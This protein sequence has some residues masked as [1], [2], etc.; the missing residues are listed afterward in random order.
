[1]YTYGIVFVEAFETALPVSI[2]G[3]ELVMRADDFEFMMGALSRDVNDG[4]PY[5]EERSQH[6]WTFDVTPSEFRDFLVSNSFLSS[7]LHNMDTSLPDWLQFLP[8]GDEILGVNDLQTDLRKG[9]DIQKTECRG[10]PLYSDRLYTVLKF[11][12]SFALS[13]FG[14]EIALPTAVSNKMYCII[15]D[16]CQDYGGSVFLILPEK[17]RDILDNVDMFKQII[18]DSG[19][20]IRP[21]GVGLSLQK[22]INV[23]AKTT[24]LQQW[25]GDEIIQYPVFQEANIWIGGDVKMAT[26]IFR[27]S[28]TTNAFLSIL[29]PTNF[30]KSFI[31]EEWGFVVRLQA[32]GALEFTFETPLGLQII[33]GSSNGE[34]NA[35]SSLGG[36]N[37][38]IFCGRNA[39][40]AGIFMSVL[41]HAEAFLDAPVLSFI[42]PGVNIKAYA[43]LAS[44][45]SAPAY[46]HLLIHAAKE[47]L[48]LKN[49]TERF[50]NLLQDVLHRYA[51]LLSNHSTILLYTVITSSQKLLDIVED[52]LEDMSDIPTIQQVIQLITGVW[53]DGWTQLQDN[54][55]AFLDSIKENSRLDSYNVTQRIKDETNAVRNGVNMLI[56]NVTDQATLL[57]KKMNGAGFRFKGDLDIY[58][59]KIIGLE[60]E[61]VYSIDSLAA[62]SRFVRAYSVLKGEKAIRV[63][64]VVSSGIK[65]GRFLRIEAGLGI[66]LAISLDLNGK[67]AALLRVEANFLGIGAQTDLFITNKGLYFYLESNIWDTYKA[68]LEIFAELGNDWYLLT[69]GVKGKF[70]ADDDENGS[71][72]DGYLAALRRFTKTIA[73]E[74]NNRISKLQEGITKAQKGVTSAQNWL[75]DKKSIFLNVN[76]KFDDAIHA[77]ERAKD[78]LED[79]KKPFQD[80]SSKLREAQRK[81]D[82]LCRIKGCNKICIP[83]IKCK[84]CRKRVWG[85]K[86]SYPCCEF[87][88]CMTSFPDP[89]CVVFNHICSAARAIAY[90]A[91][92]NAKV[93]VRIPML[94]F[95]AAKNALSATQFIYDQSRVIL[96]IA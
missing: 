22:H 73:D 32:A 40:P 3:I 35:L 79:A 15:V 60:I 88:S 31:L 27:V 20:Y 52:V 16:I 93:F 34:V 8:A 78:K 13:I 29:S 83:G 28:G 69:F 51:T 67:F 23:H 92:E 18:N 30:L 58:G 25:N 91:L 4:V 17:S 53:K 90:I 42:K 59:L 75:E 37:Q 68:Q 47:V 82:R 43:F 80:A 63:L 71:F 86:I 85:R 1:M 10:A 19:L 61:L 62:C 24:H 11:S 9:H 46:N 70:V 77:L 21:I 54:T 56:R 72:D 36:Y 94:A 64:G 49:R 66:G 95:D 81:V 44:D 12:S 5:G 45:P 38:R 96:D 84:T 14:Q 74:A 6:C 89:V 76:S 33:R 65:F 41:F 48:D 2:S 7:F 55:G 57:F 26:H 87:T 50:V 39:N